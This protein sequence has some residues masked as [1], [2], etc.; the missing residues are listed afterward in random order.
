MEEA[1]I[2]THDETLFDNP[3]FE[4]YESTSNLQL[5]FDLFFVANLTNFTQ[6][7]DI[8]SLASEFLPKRYQRPCT[9]LCTG[10]ASY[11]GFFCI[12]WFTWCQVTLYDVRFATDSVIERI[13]HLCHF[14]V[15]VLKMPSSF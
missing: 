11:I 3:Q 6:R 9:D 2:E 5:F 7:H 1:P 10:L 8:N 13:S 15:M 14:G 12:L 4:H